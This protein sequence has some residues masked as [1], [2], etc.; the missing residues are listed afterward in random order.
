[1]RMKIA[2]LLVCAA[3]ASAEEPFKV[4]RNLFEFVQR[5]LAPRRGERG[6]G[7]RGFLVRPWR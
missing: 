4:H 5:P 6:A 2:V 7:V 3:T 1:M